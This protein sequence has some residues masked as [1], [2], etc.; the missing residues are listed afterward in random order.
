MP[1]VR[2]SAIVERPAA[3][4]YE[5]VDD[6]ERYPEFL[7]WCASTEVL[8]RTAEVTRARM[9]IDYHGLKTHITTRN[10][11]DAPR[12]MTLEFVEGPFERFRGR[13]RF[14]P[15]GPD[16]CRIEFHLDYTLASNALAL[17]LGPVFGHIA[18]T[19]VE[20]FVERAEAL[21]TPKRK[22]GK[23]P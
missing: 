3:T 7:P 13:W 19:F 16:G 22:R 10:V 4:L 8:E 21:A 11:K 9:D 15:L 20:R 18:D 23:H 5:L 12:S 6:V 14:V 17:V 1:A 2:K